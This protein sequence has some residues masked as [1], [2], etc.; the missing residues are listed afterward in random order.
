MHSKA[1]L[2]GSSLVYQLCQ[3]SHTSCGDLPQ[4][5]TFINR[6]EEILKGGT[7]TENPTQGQTVGAPRS[8]YRHNRFEAAAS[9]DINA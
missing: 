1:L 3:R 5:Q 8:T 2:S 4:V 7:K 9:V 6:L